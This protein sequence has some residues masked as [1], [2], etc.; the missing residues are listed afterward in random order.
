MFSL[1]RSSA[2]AFNYSDFEK[3]IE[4]KTNSRRCFVLEL[5]PLRGGKF[6]SHTHKTVLWVWLVGTS[7]VFKISREDLHIFYMGVPPCIPVPLDFY[8]MHSAESLINKFF[9][10][11]FW[12][13]ASA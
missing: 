13:A 4:P 12:S 9:G 1:G 3:G 7:G 11:R 5:V 2:E 10:K 8:Y 6:S